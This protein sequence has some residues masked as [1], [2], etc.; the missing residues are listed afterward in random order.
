MT[1]IYAKRLPR[2]VAT[3]R[4]GVLRIE[5]RRSAMPLMLPLLAVLLWFF[6]Y[7]RAFAATP[8]WSLRSGSIQDAFGL[9]GPLV[10]G[11]AT[12]MASRERR[13]HITDLVETTARPRWTRQL[14]AWGAVIVWALA[15]YAAATA[16]LF[17]VTAQ[18]ATWGGPI[19]WPVGVGGAGIVA[20]SAAGFA[21]GSVLPS[22][23]TAPLVTIGSVL[24]LQI[25]ALALTSH[26]SPYG[27]LAP[28]NQSILAGSSIFVSFDPG[29][30][31][32][33]II[34][35]VGVAAAA[36]GALGLPAA[37][38]GPWTRRAAAAL[39]LAGVLAAGTGAALAGTAREEA[40]GTVIPLLQG[41]AS[42][43]QVG[44]TPVCD[45]SQVPVC[46]HPAFRA[47]LPSIA[48]A[49]GPVTAQVAGLPGMPVRITQSR[50]DGPSISGPYSV[51]TTIGGSPPVLSLELFPVPGQVTAA[52]FA[53]DLQFQ[54]AFAIT[55]G[56]GGDAGLAIAMGMVI[57]AG[58]RPGDAGG[59]RAPIYAAAHRFA[60]LSPQARR[61][62]L[63]GHL[64][65]LRSGR[66]TLEELP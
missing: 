56:H 37:S 46:V 39:A 18:Q 1:G 34:F 33:Q 57:A 40:G 42:G 23:F 19:W 9:I 48:A 20:L 53:Q 25:G 5:L 58:G 14:A 63:A 66:L 3:R 22:R 44:Y 45:H 32:V 24:A 43:R 30:A 8:L 52:M 65:A 11:V 50:S 12:W 64:P 61:A 13:R 31:I 10:A 49:V 28:V 51:D 6:Q 38:G 4:A 41:A 35:L 27:W 16:V 17:A 21:A 62:W 15:F 60:A 7:R 54:A 29:V 59:A 36:L 2:R 26:H 55:G 47:L